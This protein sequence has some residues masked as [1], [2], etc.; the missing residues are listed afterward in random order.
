MNAF[1]PAL[2]I[3]I[4]VPNQQAQLPNPKGS[5][6]RPELASPARPADGTKTVIAVSIDAAGLVTY[7]FVK[8]S[9]GNVLFDNAMLEAARASKY[10]SQ[11]K[12][13]TVTV[14]YEYND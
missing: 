1:L 4:S 6:V 7:A 3:A 5:M 12:P 9:S 10:K 8:S 11:G 14:E 2:L 13:A